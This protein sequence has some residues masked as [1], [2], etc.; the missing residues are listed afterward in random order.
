MGRRVCI[1]G[2]AKMRDKPSQ[3]SLT[4]LQLLYFDCPQTK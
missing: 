1:R 4:T 2:C 3:W